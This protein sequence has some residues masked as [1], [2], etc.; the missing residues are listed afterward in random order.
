M[1]KKLLRSVIGQQNVDVN[2]FETLLSGAASVMN[3]RPLTAASADVNDTL[4]IRV[5]Q[6]TEG[7]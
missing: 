4:P 7:L 5:C 6:Y 2:D 1:V 3:R